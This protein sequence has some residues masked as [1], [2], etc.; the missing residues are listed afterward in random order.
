[1]CSTALM[2][3]YWWVYCWLLIALF[4]ETT[5]NVWFLSCLHLFYN[6]S[7]SEKVDLAYQ[8]SPICRG[9]HLSRQ[10][11]VQSNLICVSAWADWSEPRLIQAKFMSCHKR[12]G[13]HRRKSGVVMVL[14]IN[15]VFATRWVQTCMSSLQ[16]ETFHLALEY[17][18]LKQM[19][20]EIF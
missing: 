13:K 5:A 2:V 6:D 9:K 1:M 8:L 7:R 17:I 12:N 15:H 20:A 4:W 19:W 3:E 11:K 14:F 18:Y 10:V 16:T